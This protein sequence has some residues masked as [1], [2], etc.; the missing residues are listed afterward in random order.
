[1]RVLRNEYYKPNSLETHL[2]NELWWD[3]VKQPSE[4]GLNTVSNLH[5]VIKE[6]S[7]GTNDSEENCT[8]P[9]SLAASYN[10]ICSVTTTPLQREQSISRN[11]QGIQLKINL[12]SF[13]LS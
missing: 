8:Y 3:S 5:A 7:L 6:K 11:N 4:D 13:Y 9:Y 12:V 1:M 10:H 2:T